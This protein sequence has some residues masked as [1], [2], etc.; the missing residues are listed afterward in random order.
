MLTAL[1]SYSQPVLAFDLFGS[2]D[3]SKASL[4][5][6]CTSKNPA[7][8]PDAILGSNGILTK[9]IN[10]IAYIAGAAAI[11]LIII[12]SFRFVVSNGDSNAVSGAR[13]TII[14]AVI[15]LI[16]IITARVII[17]FVLRKL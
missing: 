8:N 3:C 6:V 9:V 2:N 12:G 15:G 1:V 17:F 13:D 16:I 11:I 14:N 4:S 7:G 5:A 10:L